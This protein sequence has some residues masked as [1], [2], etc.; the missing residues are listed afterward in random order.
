MSMVFDRY[1]RHCFSQRHMSSVRR[2]RLP[3]HGLAYYKS[4]SGTLQA[5]LPRKRC[6]GSSR[7]RHPPPPAARGFEDRSRLVTQRRNR[8]DSTPCHIVRSARSIAPRILQSDALT[9]GIINRGGAD[10]ER[11][12]V[13]DS[14]GAPIVDTDAGSSEQID[15][16]D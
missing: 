15:P 9:D 2:L 13:R 3:T 4:G 5:R 11:I 7:A 6:C 1:F 8:G 16:A 10:T 14:L 12:V